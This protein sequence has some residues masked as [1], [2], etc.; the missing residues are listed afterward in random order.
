MDVDARLRP[1]RVPHDDPRLRGN[2]RSGDG[3]V[4]EKLAA[5]IRAVA[6]ASLQY[7][8]QRSGR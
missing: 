2:T 8:F 3:G 7:T 5:G 4:R 1:P 6:P